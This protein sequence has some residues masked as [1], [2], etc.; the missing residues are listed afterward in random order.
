MKPQSPPEKELIY[1][2]S[3]NR[4]LNSEMFVFSTM[5]LMCYYQHG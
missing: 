3:R 4:Y 5:N 2:K 1:L